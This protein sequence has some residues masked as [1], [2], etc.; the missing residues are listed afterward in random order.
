[1][2]EHIYKHEMD[3]V[4]SV[5]LQLTAG[6]KI[7]KQSG[8]ETGKRWVEGKTKSY[9]ALISNQSIRLLNI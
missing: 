3:I 1:M 5:V 7:L 8:W 9:K 2:K 6:T 4:Q